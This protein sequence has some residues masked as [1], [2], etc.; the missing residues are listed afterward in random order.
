M[1]KKI[2]VLGIHPVS[3]GFG[4]A[5]L[6]GARDIHDWGAIGV[7]RQDNARV[8]QK[9]KSLVERFSPDAIAVE[10][11]PKTGKARNPRIRELNQSILKFSKSRRLIA[12]SVSRTEIENMLPGATTRAAIAQAV[13]ERLPSLARVLPKPRK[14]WMSEPRVM[15]AF[16][17]AAVALAVAVTT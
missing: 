4:W 16:D 6:D 8:L 14:P 17:A 13:A 12:K 1:N 2:V 5:L 10:A 9:V 15:A 3:R 7:E 11:F